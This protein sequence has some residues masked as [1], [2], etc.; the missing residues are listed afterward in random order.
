VARVW[1]FYSLALAVSAVA[2]FVWSQALYLQHRALTVRHVTRGTPPPPPW[3]SLDTVNTVGLASLLSALAALVLASLAMSFGAT[4]FG[5]I[6]LLG[7]ILLFLA[8][9]FLFPVF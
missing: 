6:V 3:I 9:F 1:A 8:V 5:T 7:E 4:R 2:C